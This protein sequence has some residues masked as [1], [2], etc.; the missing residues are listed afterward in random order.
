MLHQLPSGSFVNAQERFYTLPWRRSFI[1]KGCGRKYTARLC[2]FSRSLTVVHEEAVR[3]IPLTASHSS[4]P[5]TA[6]RQTSWLRSCRRGCPLRWT[7][8]PV[9]NPSWVRSGPN[10]RRARQPA[11]TR[12]PSSPLNWT[13]DWTST[14]ATQLL[15]PPVFSTLT[16]SS[17]SSPA[18]R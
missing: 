3:T 1:V 6:W 17:R 8:N 7:Q 10:R 5:S 4:I 9:R 13:A 11:A 14:M 2:S 15:D 12:R 16:R 18:N